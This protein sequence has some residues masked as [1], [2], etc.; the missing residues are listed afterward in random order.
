MKRDTGVR[1]SLKSGFDDLLF[2]KDRHYFRLNVTFVVCFETKEIAMYCLAA[3][4]CMV[5]SIT[6]LIP[7]ET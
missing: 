3:Y 4:L 7:I 6:N 1:N 2:L 5:E